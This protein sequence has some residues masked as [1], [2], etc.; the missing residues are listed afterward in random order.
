MLTEIRVKRV[1]KSSRV[2][3]VYANKERIPSKIQ[4]QKGRLIRD[5]VAWT[6]SFFSSPFFVSF[7]R[8]VFR[9]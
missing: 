9:G 7:S 4:K 6:N 1:Q 2:R 3:V 8:S 5:I